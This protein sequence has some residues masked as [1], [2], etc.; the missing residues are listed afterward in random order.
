MIDRLLILL[1][2]GKFL[3]LFYGRPL[4]QATVSSCTT[5][6]AIRPRL[7]GTTEPAG[8]AG[9]QYPPP[10]GTRRLAPVAGQPSPEGL[11]LVPPGPTSFAPVTPP[12][13]GAGEVVVHLRLRVVR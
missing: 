6:R 3:D 4:D 13:T 5:S 12:R 1:L 7:V 2:A 8:T 10:P 11:R 9:Q